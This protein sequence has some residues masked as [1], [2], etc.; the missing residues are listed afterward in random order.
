METIKSINDV[1]ID[2]LQ[3]RHQY[4]MLRNTLKKHYFSDDTLIPDAAD[5][6][7]IL[8]KGGG[9][10]KG[11]LY[12]LYIACFQSLNYFQELNPEYLF[13]RK[14]LLKAEY[15]KDY[16]DTEQQLLNCPRT[17][18]DRL[19]KSGRTTPHGYELEFY[20]IQVEKETLKKQSN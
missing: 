4:I 20:K 19:M 1:I 9:I 5:L 15:K 7:Y 18:Q 3:N 17:I 13:I 6:P 2:E 16:K 11:I 12:I 10:Q 8:K 14:K